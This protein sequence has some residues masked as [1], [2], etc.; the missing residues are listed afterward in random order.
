M[1]YKRCIND[2]SRRYTG[3]EPSPKG[4]GFCAHG[5]KE[6]TILEGKDSKRWIAQT[7]GL[8]P[9]RWYRHPG[10][11]RTSKSRSRSRSRSRSPQETKAKINARKSILRGLRPGSF[12]WTRKSYGKLR[13]EQPSFESISWTKNVKNYPAAKAEFAWFEVGGPNDFGRHHRKGS[14]WL[15]FREA[16]GGYGGRTYDLDYD[17]RRAKFT[18][19]P[20]AVVLGRDGIKIVFKHK[21][22]LVE[23]RKAVGLPAF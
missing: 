19:T 14:Y 17:W 4:R 10:S 23:L 18:I 6:N 20:P 13:F 7:R 2:P 22:S 9:K 3:K 11:P 5:E 21:A 15:A 1:H 16:N 8:A 12:F